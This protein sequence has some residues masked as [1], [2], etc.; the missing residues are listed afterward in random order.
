MLKFRIY[1]CMILGLFSLTCKGQN[2]EVLA[3]FII[4]HAVEN[5]VD[6]TE[7]IINSGIFTVF[8]IVDDDLYMANVSENHDT[9]SW[10]RVWGTSNRTQ[11]ETATEYK[12]DIFRFNWSYTNNYDDKRGTCKV[13]FLKVYKPQGVVS[14]LRMVTESLDVI[15]YTGYMEGSINFYDF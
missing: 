2:Q 5:N 8:Y 6:I 12:T 9:Q 3:K 11:E 14:V 7:W 4:T 13:E 10:G 15:E 1:F